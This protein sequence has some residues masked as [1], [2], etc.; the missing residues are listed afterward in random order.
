MPASR[1]ELEITE[2]VLI[3]DTERT[4][5]V[6]NT[7]KS[8]GVHIAMDDFGTGY[9]SLGYLRRFPFDKIK[10][11]RSF[12]ADLSSSRDAQ[13]IVRAIIGLGRALG[14]HVNAEGVETEEQATALQSE[15]CEEVQG[16][17]YGTPMAKANVEELLKRMGAITPVVES[18][19]A[20]RP[21][22]LATG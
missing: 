21:A 7:L 13:A 4:L 18:A 6:L 3:K 8:L 12:I 9:S 2:E 15:G 17:F 22:E 14:I 10:I 5:A 19:D 20:A 16:Y 1:L 11:D